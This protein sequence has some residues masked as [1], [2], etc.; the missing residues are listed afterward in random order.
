MLKLNMGNDKPADTN[1]IYDAV[2]IGSGPAGLTAAL[3]LGRARQSVLVIEEMI[4][5]GQA[6][7]TDKLENY[8]G[9]PEGIGG[10]ELMQRME[11]QAKHFSAEYLFDKV[12]SV[13]LKSDIK[14][15]KTSTGREIQ[16]K[17]VI[18]STGA[19]PRTI[20]APGSDK[21]HGKGISYC[22]TCDGPLFRDK[23]VVVVGGGNSAVEEGLFITRFVKSITYVQDLPFLTAEKILQERLKE[24]ENITIHTGNLV[25]AFNGNEQ[26]ES[27]TVKNS[28]TGEEKNIECQGVFVYIGYIPNTEIFNGQI[29]MD[30]AGYIITDEDLHTNIEGVFA[31]GDVRVKTL[32]QVVTAVADGAI[33]AFN[34]TKY[35]ENKQK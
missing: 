28:E 10:M 29:E 15:I 5:G 21:F 13:D 27:I 3:Y 20:K 1:K 24:H 2:I 33:A 18:I 9:F 30:K 11:D 6:S 4:S 25:T 34:V 22:A 16:A 32:R 35:L 23:D 19:H 17:T 12:E 8:P 31:A 26:L 7:T 14:K